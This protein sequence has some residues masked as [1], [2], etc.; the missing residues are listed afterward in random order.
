[1]IDLWLALIVAGSVFAGYLLGVWETGERLRRV[2][3]SRERQ[4]NATIRAMRYTKR[5]H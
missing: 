3:L 4:R 1:M 5:G 2:G